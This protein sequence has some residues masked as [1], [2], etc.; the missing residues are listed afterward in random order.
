MKLLRKTGNYY[1][2]APLLLFLAG[3]ILFFF[4]LKS[5]IN[6]D[7]SEKLMEEKIALENK[8]KLFDSIP[9]IMLAL[10]GNRTIKK[11]YAPDSGFKTLM[12]D[13]ILYDE[14][15]SHE[16]VPARA[17]RFFAK[18]KVYWYQITLS[19]SLVESDDLIYAIAVSLVV[20]IALFL[21]SIYFITIRVSKIIWSPF[22][23][24]L[25]KIKEY[26]LSRTSKMQMIPSD[27]DEF[28]EL[29]RA[30]ETMTDKIQ[31]DYKNLKEFTE[32]AS[33][34]IQTPLAIIQAKLE[35]LMQRDNLKERDMIL[36]QTISDAIS[37]LS[38]LNQ[39]LLLLAKI[40]NLQ[41]R[42][43][44]TIQLSGLFQRQIDNFREL[45][46]ARGL[47]LLTHLEEECALTINPL[48]GDILITN[49]ITNAI[50]H[51]VEQGWIKV[52]LSQSGLIISNTGNPLIREPQELFGRFRKDKS[53]SESP[54]LGLAI[55]EKICDTEGIQVSY[56]YNQLIHKVSLQFNSSPT[57]QGK[58]QLQD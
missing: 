45:I 5:Y 10:D 48:L 38:K 26:D 22:Y 23:D 51:N 9:G 47:T 25:R 52:E 30:I 39:A 42:H 35:L 17:I 14:L 40:E 11:V 32:N 3:G 41:Y 43:K 24:S 18:S 46:E 7:V 13:T 28:N 50:R 58:Q 16:E 56:T 6:K 49:L 15:E 4:T 34:E 27:I 44:E 2:I 21:I 31:T 57:K 19:K 33:H 36:I 1:T 37:R 20:L 8:I 54:G 12:K 29:N 55:V 53:D